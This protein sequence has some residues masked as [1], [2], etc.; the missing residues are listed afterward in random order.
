MRFLASLA[1]KAA[2]LNTD[3]PAVLDEWASSLFRE[4]DYREEAR[5]GLKFRELFGKFR[6]VSVPE[7]YLEQTRRR[8]LIME[9]IEGEKLSEVRDQYLVE[10]H[11]LEIFC[12]QLMGN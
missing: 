10:I 5:N 4:M 8:V 11:T 2:K 3:L 6:D 7:M 12:V 9:W 1:R